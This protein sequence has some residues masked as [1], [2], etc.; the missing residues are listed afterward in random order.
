MNIADIDAA[1][2][3]SIEIG[4][5]KL[6]TLELYNAGYVIAPTIS[7]EGYPDEIGLTPTISG[8]DFLMEPSDLNDTHI[9]TEIEVLDESENEVWSDTIS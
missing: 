6:G 2:V 7:I 9:E 3:G 5:I 4:K 8:G 1:Y